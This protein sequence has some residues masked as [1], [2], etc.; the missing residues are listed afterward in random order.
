MQRPCENCRMEDKRFERALIRAAE[1]STIV[2][3][4]ASSATRER[5][6]QVVDTWAGSARRAM[7]DDRG[8]QLLGPVPTRDGAFL[9]GFVQG[10]TPVIVSLAKQLVADL[11]GAGVQG[12]VSLAPDV[13]RLHRVSHGV[14][15]VSA[16]VRWRADAYERQQQRLRDTRGDSG[17]SRVDL[18]PH[19]WSQ[20][21][22]QAQGWL[23][24]LGEQAVWYVDQAGVPLDAGAAATLTAQAVSTDRL[25]WRFMALE[26]PQ[27]RLRSVVVEDP[28]RVLFAAADNARSATPAER[29]ASARDLLV[30]LAPHVSSAFAA[31]SDGLELSTRGLLS[32]AWA[33][34][35]PF[36]L[37]HL[38]RLALLHDRLLLDAF[39]V[40]HLGP[41]FAGWT[42]VSDGPYTVEPIGDSRLLVHRQPEAWFGARLGSA[43]D[44][45]A[46]A[47]AREALRPLLAT[48]GDIDAQR[49][50]LGAWRGSD[51][52][53]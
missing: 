53:S 26:G 1:E 22:A 27:A 35:L 8:A 2:W 49:R 23:A 34:L 19:A 14:T 5:L 13:W 45:T 4:V 52:T 28:P 38:R 6:R 44:R 15:L 42:P 50:R 20:V 41:G 30:T 29:A 7:V 9:V 32:P 11:R 3:V 17:L 51:Q 43:P 39:G 40:V 24:E 25:K 33:E 31:N 21:I 12:Q 48:Q 16:S 47:G 10:S 37:Y 18:D 36:P 46:L